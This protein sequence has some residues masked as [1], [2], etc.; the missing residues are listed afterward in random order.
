MFKDIE[1][2]YSAIVALACVYAKVEPLRSQLTDVAINA[3]L[4][5]VSHIHYNMY[6]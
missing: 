2:I 5:K 4:I 6:H 3:L 1:E